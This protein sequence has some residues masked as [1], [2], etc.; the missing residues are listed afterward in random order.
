MKKFYITLLLILPLFVFSQ[1]ENDNWYFGSS[2]A[3]NF[4]NPAIPQVL[5]T[6]Q[7][8]TS[9]SPG[10]VSDSSGKLMFYTN[11]ENIW[12]RESQIMQNGSLQNIMATSLQIVKHPTNP[13]L[14]YVFMMTSYVTTKL[15]YSIVD[16]SQG[17]LG[18]DGFPLGKVVEEN[19]NTIIKD[20]YD[21]SS[22]GSDFA[23][24]PK[25]NGNAFWVVTSDEDK[26]LSYSVD[27]FGVSN[28]PVV[29]TI[30]Y[31]PNNYTPNSGYST[32]IKV[33]P[34]LSSAS[35][36][37]H[38]M[39][40]SKYHNYEISKIMSFQTVTGQITNNYDLSIYSLQPTSSEF[41]R[42]SKILYVGRN[43]D[44]KIFAVDLLS[45]IT[46]P[47]YMQI[48]EN[49]DPGFECLGIQRNKYNDIY[50]NFSNYGYL[51]KIMNPDNYGSSYL[52]LNN[53]YLAGN[54]ASSLLPRLINNSQCYSNLEMNSPEIYSQHIY[55]SSNT[56]KTHVNYSINS[57]QKITMTA[58]NN[59]QLLPNTTISGEYLATIQNCENSSPVM[60]QNGSTSNSLKQNIYLDSLAKIKHEIKILISPN[61]TTEILNIKSESKIDRIT[62][63]D[64]T[65]RKI[66]VRIYDNKVD[67]KS[68]PSGTY[69]INIET[70]DGVSKQKFIKK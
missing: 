22:W 11:G 61:P 43:N 60:R 4:G 58:E 47:S 27:N 37:S 2:A 51:S 65:G 44:S 16:M 15:M 9:S 62:V 45:S 39:V 29:S 55:Q 21:I 19:K 54:N 18:S 13:N 40:V 31:D 10:S 38:Y 64:M 28:L 69:L 35:S 36:F 26:L 3:V 7:M 42:D 14:Y 50:L 63:L 52:D 25:N 8:S 17:G 48:Y 24:V 6:S 66:N 23:I 70:K 68:L 33:S 32:T 67:V 46:V 59:I 5:T 41:N 1:G 56:I 53:I 57:G 20:D 30:S 12:T 34:K 49:S